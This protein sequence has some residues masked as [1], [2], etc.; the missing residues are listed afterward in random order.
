M[1]SL[2]LAQAEISLI[3]SG[4]MT[5]ISREVKPQPNPMATEFSFNPSSWPKKPWNARFEIENINSVYLV[6]KNGKIY[7]KQNGDS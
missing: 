2:P 7:K 3:L 4:K 1:K 6:I 5:T